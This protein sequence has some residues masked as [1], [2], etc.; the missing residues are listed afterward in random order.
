MTA[1]VPP[2]REDEEGGGRV[3]S[4]V[5]LRTRPATSGILSVKYAGL[6]KRCVS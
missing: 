6:R 2:G 5:R 1:I 3:E 4:T